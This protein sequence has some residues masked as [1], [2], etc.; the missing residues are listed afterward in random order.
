MFRDAADD[1]QDGVI[2]G[3]RTTVGAVAVRSEGRRISQDDVLEHGSGRIAEA[4]EGEAASWIE[5]FLIIQELVNGLDS[6]LGQW[7]HGDG[8]VQGQAEMG[9]GKSGNRTLPHLLFGVCNLG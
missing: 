1:V 6:G 7:A 8:S 5:F 9:R 4:G 3:G 2:E